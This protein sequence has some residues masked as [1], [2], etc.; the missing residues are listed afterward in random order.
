[1]SLSD[2]ANDVESDPRTRAL[3]QDIARQAAAD[4]PTRPPPAYLDPVILGPLV[5]VAAY[6]LYRA[7]KLGFDYLGG[8]AEL[9]LAAR[10]ATLVKQLADDG[11][12]RD[13]AEKVVVAMLKELRG[14]KADDP[15]V[16][17]ILEIAKK[18]PTGA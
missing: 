11:L 6:A 12:P 18:Y 1:M 15:S 4:D 16:K 5:G 8:R 13:K 14:R 10:Q 3:L 17:A 9:D 2:F 7:A